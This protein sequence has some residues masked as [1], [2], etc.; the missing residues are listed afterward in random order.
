M[1][2]KSGTEKYAWDVVENMLLITTAVQEAR[3]EDVTHMKENKLKIVM[4][5]EA[6]ERTGKP[7]ISTK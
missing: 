7:Q 2:L 5:A 1:I 4:R 6:F 3:K